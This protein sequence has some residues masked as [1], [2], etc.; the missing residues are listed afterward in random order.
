MY[1]LFHTVSEDQGSGCGE[2]WLGS[3]E[4]GGSSCLSCSHLKLGQDSLGSVPLQ[5]P[6]TP[7]AQCLGQKPPLPAMWLSPRS[8]HQ[9]L[10]EKGQRWAGGKEEHVL[11]VEATVLL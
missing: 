11:K 6:V 10:L 4:V 8:S 5:R 7:V 9:S 3:H 2:A 1:L